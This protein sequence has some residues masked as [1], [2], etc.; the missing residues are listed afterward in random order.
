[1]R[2]LALELGDNPCMASL[3]VVTGP[4]GAGKSTVARALADSFERS[5][6]VAGDAF[7]EFLAR[8][9]TAPWLPAAQGQNEVVIRAAAVAA[10]RF[11]A[12]GFITVYDGVL[13]PWFL[14][15]FAAEAALDDLHYVV[16]LPSVERCVDQVASR[17][18]HGFT[19]EEATRRM[20]RQFAQADIDQRHVL[21]DLPA[22]PAETAAEIARRVRAGTLRYP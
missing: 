6:L 15:D 22:S 4:P 19:D 16:L 12:G 2:V 21:A 20:Y 11:V 3:V 1:V 17:L 9:A 18:G 8:G 13:G 14:A 7:F 5:V 10:G